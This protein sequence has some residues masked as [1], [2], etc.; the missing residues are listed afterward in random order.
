VSVVKRVLLLAFGVAG[1]LFGAGLIMVGAVLLW[2]T[3]R[4]EFLSSGPHHLQ[5][6]THALVSAASLR[7]DRDNVS[8]SDIEYRIRV[9]G[10]ANAPVF[11]GMGP[12]ADVR[13]YLAGVA[14]DQLVDIRF[15]P[16]RYQVTRVP[17]PGPPDPPAEQRFWA[18]SA[19][20]T[21]DQ[22][23][24]FTG[25]AGDYQLVVMNLDGAA[26]V[27]VQARFELRVPVLRRVAVGLLVAGGVLLVAGVLLLVR[28]VRTGTTVGAAPM[29]P[30]SDH[31]V[32]NPRPGVSE[33]D[34]DH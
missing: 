7:P 18:A 23:L 5:T 32:G 12:A 6:P 22:T 3:G 25:R 2:V 16:F 14:H 31:L 34:R 4:G 1:A 17:G 8:V 24:A 11:V 29:P 26:P 28:G 10:D 9:Q 13:R 27:G 15:R 33:P 20:G 21:G 19:S 30:A